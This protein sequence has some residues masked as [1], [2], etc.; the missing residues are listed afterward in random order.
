M[1]KDTK[2]KMVALKRRW[3]LRRKYFTVVGQEKPEIKIQK[4]MLVRQI[5]DERKSRN[6]LRS[7][8]GNS[9]CGPRIFSFIFSGSPRETLRFFYFHRFM[10]T[11]LL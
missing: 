9:Y 5:Y 10:V 6:N 2:T 1:F 8:V 4:N 7:G 3:F 11:I